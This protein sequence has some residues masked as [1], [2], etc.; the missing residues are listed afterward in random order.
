MEIKKYLER[1]QYEGVTEPS[2]EVLA[3]LQQQHLLHVPFENLD[4]HNHIKIDLTNLF[5]KIV[6]MK[7]G[8]FCYEL[9]GLFYKLLKALDFTVKIVSA[10]VFDGT[11]NY[12]PE[13][14]HMTLL[15]KIKDANYLVDVGFGEFSLHPIKLEL[16]KNNTDLRGIFRVEDFDDNYKVVKKMNADG[17]FMPEYIFSEKERQTEEFY[18]MCNYHQTDSRSHFMKKRICSLPVNNGRITLTG[19]T[20]KITENSKV[21]ERQLNNED[22]VQEVLWNYFGIKL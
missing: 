13:F 4:I 18:G 22:E 7:R 8:G 10:R 20:L 17:V 2:Y 14:D 21:T 5:D 1:I 12:T 11:K 3:T 16:D 9:N 19:N 6:T 15:V